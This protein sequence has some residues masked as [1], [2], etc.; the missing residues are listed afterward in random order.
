[1]TYKGA[2]PGAGN[3]R[4]VFVG[5]GSTNIRLEDIDAGSVHTWFAD[6]VTVKGGDYGPC[7]A[8]WPP[9]ANVCGN[10]K[11]DVSKNVVVDGATFHDYRFDES[12]FTVSGADCHWECMYIN[13]GENVTIRNSKF[14]G[15]AIFDIFTTISGPDA[16]RMGHKNLVIENN[17]FGAAF[18][19]WLGGGSE[20]ATAL[21]LAWCGNSSLG[22]R[23]VNIRFNSF[24]A[25][26]NI[27]VDRVAGC[28]FDNVRV[29]GNLMMRGTC[30]PGFA[31]AYNVYSTRW[32]GNLCSATDRLLGA[33]FP[34]ADGAQGP[35]MDF[36][37]AAPSLVDGLVPVTAGCPSTDIDGQPRPTLGFC[38]AGSDER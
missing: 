26:A 35:G 22:Y 5:P 9:S 6:G 12:C 3:Q 29:T 20:R 38:D 1:L 10:S 15:C 14:R 23:D 34:Y 16:A 17:W 36:H 4:G 25:N 2:E 24:Q 11:F 32:S 33:T 37:L 19:E 21:M 27:T 18:N 28:V 8:T 30:E 7:H 31:Y 13:G